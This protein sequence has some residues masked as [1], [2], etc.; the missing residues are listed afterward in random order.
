MSDYK[1]PVSVIHSTQ[2]T[3]PQFW[4]GKKGS[5]RKIHQKSWES[6]CNPKCLDEIGF[7]DL[8]VFNEALLGRQSWKLVRVSES[9][10]CLGEF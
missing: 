7:R 2:S 10:I 6:L 3:M 8:G 1:V 5:K 4:W 9:L